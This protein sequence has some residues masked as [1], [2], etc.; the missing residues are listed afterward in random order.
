MFSMIS[1][2]LFSSATGG[3]WTPLFSEVSVGAEEDVTSERTRPK[4]TTYKSHCCHGTQRQHQ[5]CNVLYL[6]E[7]EVAEVEV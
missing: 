6:M 4:T 7:E 2:A 5:C 1:P 3:M